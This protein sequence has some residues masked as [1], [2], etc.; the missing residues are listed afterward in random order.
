MAEQWVSWALPLPFMSSRSPP[1][2][3][4]GLQCS[5]FKPHPLT[6]AAFHLVLVCLACPQQVT[7]EDSGSIYATAD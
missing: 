1:G 7:R 5:C 4:S 2:T 3:D 6:R